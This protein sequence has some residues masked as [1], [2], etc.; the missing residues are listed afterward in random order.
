[1]IH[2]YL[3]CFMITPKEVRQ[4]ALSLPETEERETWGEATFRVRGKIFAIL[5]PTGQGAS[6]KGSLE[7]QE[8]LLTMDK[9]TFAKSHYTGRFGWVS[10]N[11]SRVD[12]DLMRDLIFEAWRRTAPRHLVRSY[13]NKRS[14]S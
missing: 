11:L 5:S 7:Q 14:S 13:I 9:E 3:L 8:M 10:V 2:V 4:T 12:P 6:V 1:M